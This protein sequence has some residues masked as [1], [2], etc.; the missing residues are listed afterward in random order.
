MKK[1]LSLLLLGGI[2]LTAVSCSAADKAPGTTTADGKEPEPSDDTLMISEGYEKL[3]LSKYVKLPALSEIKISLAELEEK[4]NYEVK[5]MLQSNA[6]YK[7]T[8]EGYVAADGDQV[9]IHYKG[10]A[11]NESD[12]IDENTLK[13]M[14]NMEYD[15]D[16]KLLDGDDLVLG[17][18]SFIGAYESEEHPENNNPGFEEQLVGMKVGETRT[19]TVTFPDSYGNS[20]DLQGKVV[21]FDVTVNAIK[22]VILPELTDEMVATYTQMEYKTIA[23]FRAY[24][25]E[26][27]KGTMSYD[28]IMEVVEFPT[29]PTELVDKEITAYVYDYIEYMHG[30][31]EL[32]D[33]E[34]K[35]IFDEQYDTASEVAE[36]TVESKLV[37]EYLCR[38]LNIQLTYGEY[39]KLRN[40]DY[41]KY[42]DYY[43][44]YMGIT[45][46]EALEEY[47]GREQMSL[48]YKHDKV[49][50]ILPDKVVFE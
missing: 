46:E 27:Y 16:G 36:D 37:L 48:Q 11:A 45:S 13:N 10:Y 15:D 19:I 26:Y 9:N 7:D 33:A 25:L 14:T 39:K 18:G 38:Q 41:T 32:T 20:A 50:K 44:Y 23:D 29:L 24:V 5:L 31:K 43:Y 4:Y 40:E 2:L 22:Q 42:A 17:S 6:T 1:L 35:T 12:K 28:A 34:I 47:Y 8:E 3:D 49:L 30:D 21:K